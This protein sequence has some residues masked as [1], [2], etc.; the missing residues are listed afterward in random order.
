MSYI[1]DMQNLA[2]IL[3]K[4]IKDIHTRKHLENENIRQSYFLIHKLG[5]ILFEH[6]TNL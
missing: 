5:K 2:N 3:D 4:H 6:L 1:L